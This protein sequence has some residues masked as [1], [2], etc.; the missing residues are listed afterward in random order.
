MVLKLVSQLLVIHKSTVIGIA[1]T[2]GIN[3][4]VIGSMST[5][6]VLQLQLVLRALF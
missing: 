1:V 3:V 6:E 5:V 2:S 4:G